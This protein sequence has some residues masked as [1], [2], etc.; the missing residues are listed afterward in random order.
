MRVRSV[1]RQAQLDLLRAQV[2]P[3]SREFIGKL[4]VDAGLNWAVDNSIRIA[5][6]HKILT[7]D[8]ES[9]RWYPVQTVQNVLPLAQSTG[10]NTQW[11]LS[12]RGEKLQKPPPEPKAPKP[13][14]VLVRLF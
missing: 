3:L 13:E 6:K 5:V 11:R 2:E 9:K 1:K 12:G 14:V 8:F 10:I 7:Y 4:F